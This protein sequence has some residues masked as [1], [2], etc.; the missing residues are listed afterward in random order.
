[1]TDTVKPLAFGDRLR[2]LR[3]AKGLTIRQL[4]R[5][6]KVPDSYISMLERGLKSSPGWDVVCRLADAL[7]ISVAEFRGPADGS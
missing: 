1:M 6:A 5:L 3:A 2:E 4:A 7:M